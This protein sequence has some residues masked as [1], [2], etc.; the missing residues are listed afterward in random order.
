MTLM[1]VLGGIEFE[2]F[3][4][5]ENDVN[6]KCELNFFF[7]D[8]IILVLGQCLVLRY[9]EIFKNTLLAH[10]KRLVK[11]FRQ[12]HYNFAC[13][14]SSNSITPNIYAITKFV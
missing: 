1:L 7:C 12:F 8:D 4:S 10:R 5:G 13:K 11:L 14:K 2:L 3:A 6:V 9:M